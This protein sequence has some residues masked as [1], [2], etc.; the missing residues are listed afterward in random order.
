MH[1]YSIIALP[2][3]DGLGNVFVLLLGGGFARWKIG[4]LLLHYL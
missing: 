1:F 3:I 2:M 4:C